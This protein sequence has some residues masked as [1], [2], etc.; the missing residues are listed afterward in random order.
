MDMEGWTEG[1][2]VELEVL[3]WVVMAKRNGTFSK[4]VALVGESGGGHRV[5]MGSGEGELRLAV[6]QPLTKGREGRG[7][8]QRD[9]FQIKVW[10][11]MK[12]SKTPFP[13][14]CKG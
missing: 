8:V 6:V 9:A 11:S 4:E 12:L 2:K 10:A 3:D 13:K 1:S 14:V 5:V 7:Q